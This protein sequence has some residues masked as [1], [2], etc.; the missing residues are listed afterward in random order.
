VTENALILFLKYPQQ[1]AVK[2]RL[3]STL[4]NDLAY[5]LYR[6][7][8]A[9][10]S[11]MTPKVNAQTI[12]VYSGPE[13]ISFPDFPGIQCLVQRGTDIGERMY[14]ALLDVFAQGFERCVL[15][16]SDTPDLPAELV[17]DALD[18][19][20]SV[21]VV[22]GPSTDGGYYLVGFKRDSLCQLLFDDIPWST[23]G[24]FSE[25]LKRIDEEGLEAAQL[26]QWSDIDDFT[27]LKRFYERNINQST[28]SQVM[29]FLNTKGIINEQ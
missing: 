3:A 15:M 16:G 19:L 1:G 25:T 28:T 22:L 5:E 17:N 21:D 29:E 11:V 2:T 26:P 6:R 24:V 7:F 12:I 8:L 10:I 14:F 4:G 27:D 20:A 13:G 18:K 9:D 23:A